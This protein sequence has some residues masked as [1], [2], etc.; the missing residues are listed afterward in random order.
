VYAAMNYQKP[1]TAEETLNQT[2]TI[3]GVESNHVVLNEETPSVV[4]NFKMEN[5]DNKSHD[6]IIS[7][8]N[9]IGYKYLAAKID[10]N[11]D[12]VALTENSRILTEHI[13]ANSDIEHSIKILL[14]TND[15]NVNGLS[16]EFDIDVYKGD[17]YYDSFYY[18][19]PVMKLWYEIDGQFY[20]MGDPTEEGVENENTYNFPVTIPTWTVEKCDINTY[21]CSGEYSIP[22]SGKKYRIVNVYDARTGKT[23]EGVT[24]DTN[25][26]QNVYG[27]KGYKIEN[28]IDA[29]PANNGN[30]IPIYVLKLE[31]IE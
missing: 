7:I 22:N 28:N 9:I 27:L 25:G 1:K 31:E 19:S 24:W 13:D 23:P 14:S 15:E 26:L 6:Y 18:I 17:N 8:K 11:I 12:G 29:G 2:I 20:R 4:M 5:T 3:D 10:G 16:S 21:E 30:K